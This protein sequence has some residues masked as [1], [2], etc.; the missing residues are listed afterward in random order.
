MIVLGIWSTEEATVM[1]RQ[2][3]VSDKSSVS[4]CSGEEERSTRELAESSVISTS[5]GGKKGSSDPGGDLGCS[6]GKK[7]GRKVVGRGLVRPAW[8]LL[9]INLFSVEKAREEA[10]ELPTVITLYL[11]W[12]F[13]HHLTSKLL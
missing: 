10:K 5:R 11:C 8:D 7:E 12:C 13:G 2:L 6:D 4:F 9:V 1:D 3:E